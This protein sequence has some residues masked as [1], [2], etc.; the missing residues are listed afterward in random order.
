MSVDNLQNMSSTKRNKDK[1][2]PQSFETCGGNHPRFMRLFE[3]MINH[4]NFKGLSSSAKVVY[5]ILKAQWRGESYSGSSVECPY[6]TFRSFGLASKT[7]GRATKELED[8]G[9]IRIERGTIQTSKNNYLRRQPNL[10]T[11]TDRWKETP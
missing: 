2:R 6:S 3:D 8:A 7:I 11:F 1:Y 4:P 10:Y 9:F 5:M